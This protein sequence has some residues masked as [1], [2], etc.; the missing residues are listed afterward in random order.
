MVRVCRRP[1][2]AVLFP[3]EWSDNLSDFYSDY[4]L[5]LLKNAGHFSPLEAPD[6]WA[7]N[8]LERV[9]EA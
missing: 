2:T 1:G 5:R 7:E 4:T 3:Q 6:V 9:R 8:V